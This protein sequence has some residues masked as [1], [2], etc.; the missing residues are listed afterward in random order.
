[1]V[2]TV[3]WLFVGVAI[4]L[5][6]CLF[7]SAC[8]CCS[9]TGGSWPRVLVPVVVACSSDVTLLPGCAGCLPRPWQGGGCI[10]TL[11]EPCVP[12]CTSQLQ[13]WCGRAGCFFTA[14]G[15]CT[16]GWNMGA[17]STQPVRT[18]LASWQAR[19]FTSG[20]SLLF[21]VQNECVVLIHGI[22]RYVR[23]KDF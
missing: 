4:H 14:H 5:C 3:C 6:C 13:G 16:P 19:L 9:C 23:F 2:H 10:A 11:V 20:G 18:T 12:G 15:I 22:Y 8:A 17:A 7:C 21:P 1:V